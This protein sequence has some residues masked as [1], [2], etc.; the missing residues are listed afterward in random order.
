MAEA[1]ALVATHPDRS[2]QDWTCLQDGVW[3]LSDYSD[4]D[5]PL[6]V[7]VSGATNDTH[8][9]VMWREGDAPLQTSGLHPD[10]EE[11]MR[12]AEQLYVE[13]LSSRGGPV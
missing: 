2:F 4:P 1:L 13:V 10:A 6:H 8:Y 5:R 7:V 9:A 11:A 12:H 3:D